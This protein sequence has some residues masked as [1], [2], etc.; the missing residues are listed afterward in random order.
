MNLESCFKVG[1]ILKAHG[2][3]GEVV[4]DFA[5]NEPE[6]YN[7]LESVFVE[8]NQK[9]VPFFIEDISISSKRAIIKFEDI[10]KIED[11]KLVL[12]RS[13]YLPLDEMEEEEEDLAYRQLIGFK[14]KDKKLGELGA[15][16]DIL[17]RP[18][19]DLIVMKY[20]EKEIYI[21]IDPSILIKVDAKKKILNVDLPEGLID[22]N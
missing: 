12:N 21:P 20:Q 14:V 6:K 11:T 19:Q 2:I 1:E 4:A 7:Q 10:D 5:V 3:R 13:L 9:L 16:V 22:I 8:I 15:I 18:G 17:E